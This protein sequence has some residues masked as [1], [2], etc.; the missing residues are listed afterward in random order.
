MTPET[1]VG[2]ETPGLA[3]I[4]WAASAGAGRHATQARPVGAV[5]PVDRPRVRPARMHPRLPPLVRGDL[6]EAR[7]AGHN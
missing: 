2:P 5:H 7:R 6:R 1:P 4:D 3:G